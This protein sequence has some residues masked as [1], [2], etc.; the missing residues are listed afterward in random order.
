M[1]VIIYVPAKEARKML[2]SGNYIALHI[3]GFY[4]AYY[5]AQTYRAR[6]CDNGKVRD[7]VFWK[8]SEYEK[9]REARRERLKKKFNK[10]Y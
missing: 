4:P 1:S 3:G 2:A 8:V 6:L 7:V 9:A 5:G 10:P